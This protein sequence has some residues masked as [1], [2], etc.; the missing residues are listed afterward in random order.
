MNNNTKIKKITGYTYLHGHQART[1]LV[2]YYLVLD[3]IIYNITEE[4]INRYRMGYKE[5]TILRSA[6]DAVLIGI[7]SRCCE[8]RMNERQLWANLSIGEE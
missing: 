5:I 2:P 6:D 7:D 8:R 4:N 1:V 3:N